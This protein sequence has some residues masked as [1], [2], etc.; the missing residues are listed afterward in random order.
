MA[1]RTK[2]LLIIASVLTLLGCTIFA[3]GM[4]MMGWDFTKLSIGKPVTNTHSVSE[5]F[6][7]ISIH[8]SDAD[9]VLVP[10]SDGVCKVVCQERE[11][12]KHSVTVENGVLTIQEVDERR[13][14]E[15]IGFSFFSTKVTVYLPEQTYAKLL[16]RNSTGSVD[17]PKDMQFQDIDI[18]VSTGHVTNLASS[19]GMLKIKTDTGHITV[20]DISAGALDLSVSTGDILAENI[21]CQG[22]MRVLVRTGKAQLRNV[23]CQSFLSTGDTGDLLL[24]Q[25]IVSEKLS[26]ERSTGDVKLDHCDAGEINIVTDTG[27]VSGSLLTEKIF[28]VRSDTGKIEVPKST[29]G[30]ICEIKTDTGDIMINIKQ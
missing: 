30:G 4:S 25:V 15:H 6:Q 7:S 12:T 16:V 24:D 14:Y 28:M 23:R 20:R 29:S 8:A 21:A 19:A 1:K 3:V 11:N 27:D 10:A 9:L 18:S 17:V 13:W 22:N 26:A 5:Q 2:I